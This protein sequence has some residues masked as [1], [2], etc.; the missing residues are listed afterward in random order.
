MMPAHINDRLEELCAGQTASVDRT[1]TFDDVAAFAQLSGD[2]NALHLDREF[3]A[4]TEFSRPVAHGFL[5]ASLLSTLIGMKLPGHGALYLSQTIE[6]SAPVFVG[7]SLV[8]T[9]TIDKIDRETRIVDLSTIINN[10]R[11]QAV[12]RGRARAKVLRLAENPASSA[13][14]ENKL[15][16]GTRP[17]GLVSGKRALVTG[18]SR[19]IGRATARLLAAQ[20]AH[21]CINY[22]HS[23]TAAATLRDEIVAEGGQCIMIKADVTSARS[24]SDL[25]EAAA[26]AA[27]LDILVN[28]AGPRIASAPFARVSWDQMA[29]AYQAIA[30]SAFNVTQAALP[31]LRKSSGRIINVIS[32]AALGRTAFHWMPYAAAKAA[33]HAMSKNLALELGPS[34]ITVNTVSPSLVATDLVSDMPERVRQDFMGRTPLRRLATV[35]DVAGAI[36]LLASPYA[37]FITGDNLL[38]AGGEIMS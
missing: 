20:G 38:V 4:R 6:F 30:G 17:A 31:H 11:G 14:S 18:A 29:E 26:G 37:S 34:G 36:L 12:L 9:A 33:L 10:Q 3:A 5:H 16:A 32:S 15:D 2:Y 27:G 23:M 21:V 19:G 35:D 28:N 7:D 1:V 24:A 13:S 25:V 8:A 22:R